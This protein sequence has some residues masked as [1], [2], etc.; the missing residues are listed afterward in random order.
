MGMDGRTARG[1]V[2]GSRAV[3]RARGGWAALLLGGVSVAG[4][5]VAQEGSQTDTAFSSTTGELGPWS[6]AWNS[7][8]WTSYEDDLEGTDIDL[9]LGR[10]GTFVHFYEISD[11]AD[12]ATCLSDI[13]PQFEEYIG[14][15]ESEPLPG[16]DGDPIAFANDINS[17]EVR[18]VSG[19]VD[20]D[21]F[22][23]YGY[24]S[25]WEIEGGATAVFAGAV[26]ADD[27]ADA[28]LALLDGLFAEVRTYVDG[29]E[30]TGGE[31]DITPVAAGTPAGEGTPL[32]RFGG[33]SVDSY[34]SP[35]YGYALGWD[36]DEWTPLG[37]SS[38]DGTD[39]LTLIAGDL[40]AD[41]R[42][43][44][45]GDGQVE[46]C[47]EDAV[48]T[49]REVAPDAA[50]M[51]MDD[52]PVV[53]VSQDGTLL[54]ALVGWTDG[55]VANTAFVTC[56]SLSDEA[57]VALVVS[58]ESGAMVDRSDPIAKLM[59]NLHVRPAD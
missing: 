10:P 51:E 2:G 17:R 26:V 57:V 12:A 23:G 59:R 30:I 5:V 9:V 47:L 37:M 53:F 16:D 45:N 44:A 21:A 46:T 55:G 58:G 36:A 15:T 14:L 22:D 31:A 38:R 41:L 8:D 49:E 33:I 35:T 24:D 34:L 29:E 11:T 19:E 7:D 25:Y 52:D 20:G 28:D 43:Y 18:T 56:A 3:H 50:I 32:A 4:P 1:A 42:G 39:I 54:T 13:V 48:A 40:H 6:V 27:V